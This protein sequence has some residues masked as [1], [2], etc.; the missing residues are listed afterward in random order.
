LPIKERGCHPLKRLSGLHSDRVARSAKNGDLPAFVSAGL[1]SRA[2]AVGAR[3]LVTDEPTSALDVS[4]RAQ[5]A[6]PLKDLQKNLGCRI[7]SYFMT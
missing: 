4:I 7:F 2:L 5:V 1:Y 3:F 6:Q